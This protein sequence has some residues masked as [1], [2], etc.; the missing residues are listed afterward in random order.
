M[1]TVGGPGTGPLGG[2]G[3]SKRVD[4]GANSQQG[5]STDGTSEPLPVSDPHNAATSEAQKSAL[6]GPQSQQVAFGHSGREY[7]VISYSDTNPAPTDPL[8]GMFF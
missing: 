1:G 4:S 2:L 6:F 5:V 3:G 8:M 7:N